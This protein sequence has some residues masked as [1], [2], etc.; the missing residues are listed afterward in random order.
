MSSVPYRFEHVKEQLS[1]EISWTVAQ[2]VNDPRIPK[3][4]TVTEIKLAQDTRNATVYVSIYGDKQQQEKAIEALNHAAPFIQKCV[5]A[6]ISIR[7]FPRLY[8]KIDSSFDRSQNINT[9]L[10]QIQDDQV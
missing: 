6:K 9:I 7:N 4:V 8:F 1:R 3:V 5:S 10:K 2:K